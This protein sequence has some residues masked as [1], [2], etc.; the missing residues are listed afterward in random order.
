[1]VELINLDPKITDFS[2]M[3]DVL[4]QYFPNYDLTSKLYISTNSDI[5]E[6]KFSLVGYYKDLKPELN[7]M[8]D[9][10]PDKIVEWEWRKKHTLQISFKREK[11]IKCWEIN[12]NTTYSDSFNFDAD[13]ISDYIVEPT[14]PGRMIVIGNRHYYKDYKSDF[15]KQTEQDIIDTF[16]EIRFIHELVTTHKI[17]DEIKKYD[18]IMK[19]AMNLRDKIKNSIIKLNEMRSDF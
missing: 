2:W 6:R 12:E 18:D 16:K 13:Y 3:Y 4:N 17:G 19:N 9:K 1:M 15:L 5:G 10:I 8:M 11:I 14:N 7:N